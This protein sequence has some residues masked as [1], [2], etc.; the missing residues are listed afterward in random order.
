MVCPVSKKCSGCQLSNL[1]YEEQLK[2]KQSTVNKLLS[3]YCKV[4]KII[5]MDEP[6]YYRNKVQAIIFT[7]S[8][9]TLSGVYQSKDG[10]TV[11]VDNCFLNFPEADPIILT[12]RKLCSGFKIKPHDPKTNK[13][14]LRHVLLRK[15]FGTGEIMCALVTNGTPIKSA[16]SF[17]N[18]LVRRHPE[19]TTITLGTNKTDM[20]LML[21]DYCEVLFGKGYIT[22]ELCGKTFKISPRSFYQVNYKQTEKLYTLAKE[23]ANVQ[24]DE[25]VI[26]AY[27]GTGT[28]GLIVAENAKKLIGVEI[29]GD[30]IKDAKEN[31]KLNSAKNTNFFCA[32]AGKLMADLAKNC[33]KV[34]VVITD[35]PRAGCS[36]KF[37]KSLAELS[38]NRVVYISCN[39]ETLSRDLGIFYKF[40]YKTEKV[41][42]VDMF[43]HTKHCEAVCLLTK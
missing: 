2:L 32:D 42:P 17:V 29:N 14:T 36:F 30:A 41:Q 18:E 5:G 28:I 3:K 11:A 12:I 1:T 13:G 23:F 27:C 33:D 19:I 31:A 9:K 22:D 26:D 4:E 40:G 25:T 24:S 21:D 10:R 20:G 15:A 38:P 6:Y 35:P 16:K 43:P 39:P 34:D 37:I 7:K 8:G